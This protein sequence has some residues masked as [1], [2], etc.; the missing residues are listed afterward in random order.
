MNNWSYARLIPEDEWRGAF[1][2]IRELTLQQ[3]RAGIRLFQRPLAEI[4]NLRATHR[5]W[6]DETI[7]PGENILGDIQGISLEILAEFQIHEEVQSFGI[8]V[9]VGPGEFT[10]IGYS[11]KD[12]KLF[13]DRNHSGI[14]NFHDGFAAIHSADLQ[15]INHTI[16]LHIFVDSS[17]VE[18]FANDSLITFADCIFPAEDSQGL[19]LFV[20]GGSIRL[21]SLDIYQL[22]PATAQV[23][24][25]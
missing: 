10:T 7:L 21:C 11:P 15:P 17:S 5:H 3:T 14:I 4:Q 24:G 1:N 6:A 16:K 25:N 23:E 2:L 12:G 22:N 20:E 13:V 9:R 19:E 8:R 18:V